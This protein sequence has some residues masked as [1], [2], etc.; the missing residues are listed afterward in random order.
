MYLSDKQLQNGTHI[1]ITDVGL[2]S[3]GG[4]VCWVNRSIVSRDFGW[5]HKLRT[6]LPNKLQTHHLSDSIG[7]YSYS[8]FNVVT[9][10]ALTRR[11]ATPATESVLTCKDPVCDFCSS[12]SLEV[13]YSS[14]SCVSSIS[15]FY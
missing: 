7:W 9:Y 6:H 3:N 12:V 2:E 14:E 11:L 10:V 4:L 5:Y 1:L 13:H 8:W 15:I